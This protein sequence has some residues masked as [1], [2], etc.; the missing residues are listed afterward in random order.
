ML[1]MSEH[2]PLPTVFNT[3]WQREMQDPSQGD[4]ILARCWSFY[5]QRM[6]CKQC[7]QAVQDSSCAVQVSLLAVAW[8]FIAR[9]LV[10]HRRHQEVQAR[11]PG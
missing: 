10:R 9:M 1:T 6:C 11:P 8:K 3:M 4:F 7:K 5:R 2:S